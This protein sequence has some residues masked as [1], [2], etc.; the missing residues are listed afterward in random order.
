MKSPSNQRK[1]DRNGSIA[2]TKI[3][4]TKS[5]PTK[6][7]PMQESWRESHARYLIPAVVLLVTAMVYLPALHFGFVCD[8]GQQIVANQGRL[9]WNSIP[10]YFTTDIWGYISPL[11]KTNYYRPVFLLWLMLNY[12]LFGLNTALW[13]ASAVA[14]HLGA[15][16]LVY[17][18]ALRLTRKRTLAGAAALL[19]GVHPVHVEAVAWLSGSS[20]TL[21]AILGLGAI[22]CHL[23][24]RDSRSQPLGWIWRAAEIGLF[25]LALFAKETAIVLP[26][27]IGAWDWLFPASPSASLKQRI[28]AAVSTVFPYLCVI[29]AYFLARYE[30]LGSV[31]PATRPWT[32]SM[33]IGTWPMTL[34]FYLRQLL[35][36]FQYSLFYPIAPVQDFGLTEAVLHLLPV[37]L[38]AGAL[39]WISR[40]SA[41]NAFCAALLVLPILPVLNLRAFALDDF[42]HDRYLYIPSVGLCILAAIAFEK[43]I[44]QTRPREAALLAVAGVLALVCVQTSAF[45]KDNLTLYSRAIEVAPKSVTTARYL[46]EELVERERWNDALNLLNP[47]L[48]N[49]PSIDDAYDIN[50]QIAKCY[51][52]LGDVDQA[53]SRFQDAIL[54]A[55]RLPIAYLD[56]AMIEVKRNLLQQADAHMRLALQ[57]RPTYS[58][59][60]ERYHYRLAR[61][62]EMEGQLNGA[63]QEYQAE[64]EERPG[65]TDAQGGLGRVQ[66]RMAQTP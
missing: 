15:T 12:Q 11:L 20:E 29:L 32:L 18:L 31:V 50:I 57:F 2:P 41:V 39:V 56:L 23:R 45:W 54:V 49:H 5:E 10:G 38:A 25:T 59:L 66:Q 44:P 30:A 3:A 22:L 7:A 14:A 55:P 40:R 26:V 17:F 37:L 61:I 1:V 9:T 64:L 27:L 51:F 43:L 63:L 33:M 42:L 46:G 35:I 8:D 19:F 47:A 36:P 4:P 28:G 6:S 34:S 13:H 24:W 48:L 58:P 53:V 65:A 60:F 52:G 16:L 21:L 62:L